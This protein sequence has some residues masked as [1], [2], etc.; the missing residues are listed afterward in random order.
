MLRN[1]VKIAL[2]N[3]YKQRLYAAINVFGLTFGIACFAFISLW[4][5]DEFKHDSFHKNGEHIYQ[6]FTEKSGENEKTIVPYIPSALVALLRAQVPEIKGITRVFPANAAF[7]KGDSR[8]LER[9]IYADEALLDMFSFPLREGDRQNLFDSPNAV[10]ITA[11]LAEKYFPGGSPLNHFIEI[12]QE[13]NKKQSYIV[14]GVLEN[15]PAH[16]SLQ[17]DFILSY[18]EFEDRYRPWWKGNNPHSLSNYNVTAYLEAEVGMDRSNLDSKLSTVLVNHSDRNDALFVYPFEE[19]YLHNDI[20]EGRDFSGKIKNVRLLSIIA[21]VILLIACINFT[22]LS[23]AI[24]SQRRIEIGLRKAIGAQRRQIIVQLVI[25]S[26]LVALVAT[27]LAITAVEIVMP[28]FNALTNK[29][30]VVPFDSI[31]MILSSSVGAIVLGVVAGLYP[32]LIFSSFQLSAKKEF[33]SKAIRLFDLRKVL[34]VTQFTLSTVFIVFTIVVFNQIKYIQEKPLGIRTDDILSHQLHGIR[35]K[36]G[37]YRQELLALP[38]VESVSFTEQDP[39]STTNPNNGVFWPGKPEGAV[40]FFNVIQVSEDFL[41]TF[42][43][44]L[45]QGRAFH[46]QDEAHMQFIINQAAADA[47]MLDEPIG[48]PLT[49]WGH[50]G[51]IVGVAENYHHQS[52][53]EQIE[54]VIIKCNPDQTWSAYIQFDT[55]N[56]QGLLTDIEAV[57]SKYEENYPF[58]YTFLDDQRL[59][60]YTDL[61]VI[62]DLTFGFALIAIVISCLGLFGLSA[63]M[64]N[65]RSKETGI[66][67]VLG[68]NLSSLVYQFSS[69]FLKLVM[70]SLALGFPIAFFYIKS[71]LSTY[72]YHIEPGIGPYVMAGL[73]AIIV[74]LLAVSYNTVK[75]ALTN[76]TDVLRNE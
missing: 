75:A 70:L 3:L 51:K 9:G 12:S 22:N 20:S 31:A 32:A 71:W 61:T 27:I 66:R 57:Y 29:N 10:V 23:T 19:M 34:V 72:A 6:A 39:I 74:A 35:E 48:S 16:S 14:G 38:G 28:V 60:S 76:P 5:W 62:G 13:N 45:I 18:Q 42:E 67:K 26:I 40:F 50:E 8:F 59:S 69:D 37:A 68:A 41:S 44:D 36:S 1:Y 52:L 4:V 15:I 24:A 56:T 54:P 30:I 43:I 21:V 11:E 47:M 73:T 7:E 2:R 63:F 58:D 64:A 53:A 17:F 46:D 33:K 49:V 65:R 55:E 25:E